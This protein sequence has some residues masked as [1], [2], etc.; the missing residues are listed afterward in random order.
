MKKVMTILLSAVVVGSMSASADIL[1]AGWDAFDS[2]LTPTVGPTASGITASAAATGFGNGGAEDRGASSDTTWG[3]FDGN[4]TAASSVIVGTGVNL[5]IYNGGTGSITLTVSN[6]GTADL[7]LANVHF[8]ALAFRP[9][10]SR[11]Y[12]LN[13]L[14]GSDITVGNVFTSPSEAITSLGGTAPNAAQ[15]QHDEIN[16]ALS[17]L[18]DRTLEVGGTAIFEIAFSGGTAGSSGH[19]LWLDNV[20][21]SAI[22]EPATLGLIAAFGGGIL[23]IRR[24]FMI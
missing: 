21:V 18:T 8:D 5:T 9:K 23:F 10:A 7:D 6:G 11:T 2:G 19:H 22:P 12:A 16:I 24:R 3:S 1:I 14:A 20:A 4:G 17:G 13:V 15:D